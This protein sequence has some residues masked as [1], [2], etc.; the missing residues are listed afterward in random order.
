MSRVTVSC[1]G[2]VLM[3][4]TSCIRLYNKQNSIWHH[5]APFLSERKISGRRK[6]NENDDN[7]FLPG[8]LLR[9]GCTLGAD[10]QTRESSMRRRQIMLFVVSSLW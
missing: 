9:L 1:I 7:E 10:R 3:Y 6:E 5:P 8:M 4:C 2:A